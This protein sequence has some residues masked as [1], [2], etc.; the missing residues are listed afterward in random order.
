MGRHPQRRDGEDQKQDV[1]KCVADL[2][3]GQQKPELNHN[4]GADLIDREEMILEAVVDLG[5]RQDGKDPDQ[6][7]AR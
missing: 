3:R 2:W 1:E 7:D 4:V 6:G 5:F